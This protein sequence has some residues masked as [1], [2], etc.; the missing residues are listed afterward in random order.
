M[1]KKTPHHRRR[2]EHK[3]NS[4]FKSKQHTIHAAKGPEN[5]NYSYILYTQFC[6]TTRPRGG[7]VLCDDD[8]VPVGFQGDLHGGV[9]E[10]HERLPELHLVLEGDEQL[11]LQ[12]GQLLPVRHAPRLLNFRYKHEDNMECGLRFCLF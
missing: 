6:K 11:L 12:F 8:L 1:V 4:I 7:N 3:R 10:L 5:V 2:H 9:V